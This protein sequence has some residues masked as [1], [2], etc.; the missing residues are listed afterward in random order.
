MMKALINILLVLAILGAGAYGGWRLYSPGANAA[1]AGQRHT[2]AA[3]EEDAS[4]PATT[5][6]A[7]RARAAG[8][9]TAGAGPAEVRQTLTL[10]GRVRYMPD[11]VR[12]IHARFPG[13]VLMADKTV[14][15]RVRAGEVLA[16]IE[17]NDSLQSY[18]VE[19]PI[20]GV[21][22]RQAASTG[23]TVAEQPLYTVANSERVWIDLA[24]FRSQLER[25]KTG[26]P[27]RISPLA[28][29]HHA[30]AVIDDILPA[31]DVHS[32]ST[33]ARSVLD[34][35]DNTWRPGMAVTAEVTIDKTGVPLAVRNSAVQRHD[36]Q[37]IVFVR[38]GERYRMQRVEIGRRDASHSEVLSG[39]EAGDDYVVRNS[40]LVKADI[41]KSAASHAH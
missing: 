13:L 2:A 1:D 15:D 10:Q 29:E 39:L 8:I 23:E 33:T 32:Q 27:V 9:E 21:I 26:Q 36:N 40:Y 14:G 25:I 7:E 4:A 35:P 17:S 41:E 34:N 12:R 31:T 24:V 6:S 5:I 38:T 30:T 16:R 37:D 19:S 3:H 20:N 28:G 11:R 18:A 22:I